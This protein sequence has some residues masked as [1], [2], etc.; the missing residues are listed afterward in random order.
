MPTE[1]HRARLSV[2]PAYYA[3]R[4]EIKVSKAVQMTTQDRVHITDLIH[5][6]N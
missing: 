2:M 3:K 4:L 1:S 6:E 5:A